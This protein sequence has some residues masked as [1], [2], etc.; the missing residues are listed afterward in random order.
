M[1]TANGS[2]RLFLGAAG[3]GIHEFMMCPKMCIGSFVQETG[4][5]H[6]LMIVCVLH[7]A[8][9]AQHPAGLQFATRVRVRVHARAPLNQLLRHSLV[10]IP[11]HWQT[12]AAQ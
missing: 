6:T 12:I 4:P 9:S 7:V 2:A 3:G 1:Q 8:A 11:G 10:A 5:T